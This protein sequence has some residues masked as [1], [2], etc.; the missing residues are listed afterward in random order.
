MTIIVIL[1]GPVKTQWS[2]EKTTTP[3]WVKRKWE[4]TKVFSWLLALAEL[5]SAGS[6]EKAMARSVFHAILKKDQNPSRQKRR[7]QED[8]RSQDHY[9]I[10][11]L[12]VAKG[13]I[14]C[15]RSVLHDADRGEEEFERKD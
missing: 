4:E 6:N 14:K 12:G 5:N 3:I 9:S 8:K 7:P 1:N 10:S 15:V 2:M 13:M 11:L